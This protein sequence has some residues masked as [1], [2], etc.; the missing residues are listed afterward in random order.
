LSA[1][2]QSEKFNRMRCMH[3]I[4]KLP[5]KHKSVKEQIKAVAAP[6]KGIN[7]TSDPNLVNNLHV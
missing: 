6:F 3:G 1:A 2:K 5:C 4:R 7:A